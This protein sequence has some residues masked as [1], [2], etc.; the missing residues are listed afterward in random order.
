MKNTYKYPN[1]AFYIL[2]IYSLLAGNISSAQNIITICGTAT[3]G[4]SGDGGGAAYAS[5]Y[6]PKGVLADT[7]GNI[8]ISDCINTCIRK[9][10][11]SGI[12]KTI[13]GRAGY[14]DFHGDG[15]PATAA[16]MGYQMGLAM[17]TAGNLYIA[18]PENQ[19]V[20]MVTT[21]GIMNTFA[22]DSI[23]GYSGDG[24]PATNASL[25]APLR[26]SVDKLGNVYITDPFEYRIRK[27]TPSGIISTFAGTGTAGYSGDGGPAT[28]ARISRPGGICVDTGGNFYF[29]DYS[30]QYI[31][32]IDTHG[33]ITTI[34]GTGTGGYSGDGGPATAARVYNPDGIC[35]DKHGNIIFA[36]LANSRVRKISPDGIISTIAGTGTGG[37]SGDGGPAT[38]A[39]LWGPTDVTL[40]KYGNVY[41][42]DYENS[43]IRE[44]VNCP[45]PAP[46]SIAG[47]SA[48]CTGLNTRLSN[49]VYGGFWTSED[50]SI[51]SV[52]DSGY[53]TG[54]AAGT[55]VIS[56]TLVDSCGSTSATLPFLVNLSA[57]SGTI[58][59]PSYICVGTTTTF[60]DSG[61]ASGGTWVSSNTRVA[62]VSAA[63]IVTAI[64]AGAVNI[65]YIVSNR[66][67]S[68]TA[69]ISLVAYEYPVA[70]HIS[71]ATFVCRGLITVL[72]DYR[73]GGTWASSDTS[74]AVVTRYTG[75][76]NAHRT[77]DDTIYYSVVNS[78]GSATTFTIV[79]VTDLPDTPALITG[80]TFVCEGATT[81]LDDTTLH[82][83]WTSSAPSV[84][85]ITS[86]YGA[87]TGLAPGT[88]TITYTVTNSCGLNYRTRD[89]TVIP[90]TYP[91]HISG[92]SSLCLG[93]H[94]TLSNS[95]TGGRWTADRSGRI[96]I[97]SISGHV[98]TLS[99]GPDTAFYLVPGV[100]GT[101]V[102]QFVVTVDTLPNAGVVS[103]AD[104]LC[105]GA[106]TLLSST[107]SGTYWVSEDA[108][109]A[110]VNITSGIITGNHPG[111]VKINCIYF[112][113][114]GTDTA[115]H[116][117]F[118]TPH[119]PEAGVIAGLHNICEGETLNLSN[120]V[121]GGVWASSDPSVCT[122]S[123]TGLLQSLGPG[124]SHI[125]YTV[126]NSCGVTNTVVDSVFVF[127]ASACATGIQE[128]ETGT[129]LH[130][131]PNPSNG[132][133]RITGKL[134]APN[135][136][137]LIVYCITDVSGREC[138]SGN[139]TSQSNKIDLEFNLQGILPPGLYILRVNSGINLKRFVIIIEK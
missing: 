83:T 1:Y 92:T 32:K 3:A 8:Y 85:S 123:A 132:T 115:S 74:I 36:D 109:I 121:A 60:V 137:N 81:L 28:A 64:S 15:G 37:F 10:N 39:Q 78:C 106:T 34:G 82:G 96:Y 88:V 67:G 42:A 139:A 35:A 44:I 72:A 59:G 77:G 4:Y 53:V 66:C 38:A 73:S 91:G 24:G 118:V 27:V 19:R 79:T 45:P 71:G 138:Y 23:S 63:G 43:R 16:A 46:T 122:V 22:G 107:T 54:R 18:D 130:L 103:G 70:G 105:Q 120:Y 61:G 134:S 69:S 68:D 86:L 108:A 76:V 89:I 126:T 52:N 58:T 2:V 30:N 7:F 29:C 57:N 49:G 125:T 56:Y 80:A 99:S 75:I 48:V 133:F 117:I 119:T 47:R 41:I 55:T 26:M 31:R 131:S 116:E 62:T 111:Y 50:T 102:A 98:A 113:S 114:C 84:A 21:S 97:D 127:S 6:Y 33:I 128:Q 5:L 40:D 25:N 112:N 9:I 13:A 51:A 95:V 110:S 100:C 101:G 12:I 135:G 90:P 65:Y 104:T 20:R 14:R 11:T 87:V 94:E 136:D 124:A 17:D 129:L 93:D